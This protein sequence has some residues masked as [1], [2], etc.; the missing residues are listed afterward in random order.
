MEHL[1][2]RAPHRD[3]RARLLRTC[4]RVRRL[5]CCCRQAP[6]AKFVRMEGELVLVQPDSARGVSCGIILPHSH[7]PLR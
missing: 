2:G 4:A 7:T 1:P 6:E 5:V 3:G